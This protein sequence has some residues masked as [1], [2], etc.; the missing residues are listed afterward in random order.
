MVA[1]V[2]VQDASVCHILPVDEGGAGILGC[3]VLSSPGARM[4]T[5]GLLLCVW[6]NDRSFKVLHARR[7]TQRF[8]RALGVQPAATRRS[9][10]HR[11]THSA[12]TR[13]PLTPLRGG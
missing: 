13:D 4:R 8:H 9:N 1:L 2:K 6:F 10:A 3:G 11:A 7:G 5:H 12:H